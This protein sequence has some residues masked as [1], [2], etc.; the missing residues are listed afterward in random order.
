MTS[1]ELKKYIIDNKKIE[2]IL[3]DLGCRDIVF[4]PAKDYYSATQPSEKSDNKMGVIIKN[5]DNLNYYSYSHNIHI[6]DGKDIFNFIEDTKNIKFGEAIQYVCKLLGLE[7]KYSINQ[8]KEKNKKDPL[9]LFKRAASK[10]RRLYYVDEIKEMQSNVLDDLFKGVHI[11]W[12]KD[13]IMPWTAE[14]FGLCYS[15]RQ[16]RQII[17][18][19]YWMDGRLVGTNAR[20]TVENYDLFNIRKYFISPGYNKTANIYGFWENQNDIE[21][22][23]Y[24][25]IFEAERSV[26]KR[27]SL[28]DSTGLALQGHSISEEQVRIILSLD[29]HEVV[30]AMDKD[31]PIEEVW[32]I[33]ERF[34]LKRTVTYFIDKY[35][36]LGSKDSPADAKNK[37]YNYLFRYRE[38][39]DEEKH[40][41]YMNKLKNKQV[42]N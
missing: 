24:C 8:K 17:P 42:K 20:T 19:R 22:A 10:R 14:K 15:Y 18:I 32:S 31:V 2:Y 23:G 5:C 26:L 16:K 12:Y 1:L 30:I 29:I 11:S 21:K 39:Y 4:H 40:N 27:D 28:H 13:G 35:K 34:Y 6:D 3:K 7:Y 25:V 9:A 41:S 36:L 38:K 37:I 33:C